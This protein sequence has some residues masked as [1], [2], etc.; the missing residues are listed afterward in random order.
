MSQVLGAGQLEVLTGVHADGC[1]LVAFE[2][3][4][5]SELIDDRVFFTPPFV[6][7]L[8]LFWVA[9]VVHLGSPVDGDPVEGE[10]SSTNLFAVGFVVLVWAVIEDADVSKIVVDDVATVECMVIGTTEEL[11]FGLLLVVLILVVRNCRWL[12]SKRYGLPGFDLVV[13]FFQRFLQETFIRV[14]VSFS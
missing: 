6:C 8:N 3:L 13:D 1:E 10:A 2:T 4:I 14:V 7:V 12:I 5:L 11:V 9:K